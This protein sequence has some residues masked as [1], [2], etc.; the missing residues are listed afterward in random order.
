MHGDGVYVV[1]H[2]EAVHQLE[3]GGFQRHVLSVEAKLHILKV[4]GQRFAVQDKANL[5]G[6]GLSGLEGIKIIA[7]RLGKAVVKIRLLCVL[8]K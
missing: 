7:V 5:V 8:I 4:C 6:I 3:I 2:E 1:D